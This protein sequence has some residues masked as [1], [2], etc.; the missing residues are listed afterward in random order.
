MSEFSN[1]TPEQ[2]AQFAKEG[3]EQ[4]GEQ[5][6]E[7]SPAVGSSTDNIL[8]RLFDGEAEGPSTG[9]LKREYELPQWLALCLRGILRAAPGRG[10][11]PIGDIALGGGLGLRKMQSAQSASEGENRDS[12]NMKTDSQEVRNGPEAET[13]VEINE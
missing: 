7:Q 9:E 12:Q 11:P 2:A 4:A 13:T 6:T 3:P 10:L 1:T 5:E 8:A